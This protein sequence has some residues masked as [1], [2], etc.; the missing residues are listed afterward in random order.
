MKASTTALPV[1]TDSRDGDTDE[2]VIR[3]AMAIL[4]A[5]M[6]IP[7]M[8]M[9]SPDT[10]KNYL[11]MHYRNHEREEFVVM[12]MSASVELIATETLSLGTLTEATVHPRE[13]VKAALKH[14]AKFAVLVH[15]HPSGKP[16][17]SP[18][19]FSLTSM[20]SEALSFVDVQV[21][22]HFIVG[23]DSVHSF[24]ESGELGR[25][26]PG[27]RLFPSGMFN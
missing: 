18:A 4:D 9:D 26:A 6:R 17:P 2:D 14:N 15:N 10:A 21:L 12:F 23:R 13:V 5:R 20:L 16:D 19:D 8:V 1:G 11:R 7:N 25:K 22:D 3:R 27:Q 24:A